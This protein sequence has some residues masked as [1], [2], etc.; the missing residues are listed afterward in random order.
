MAAQRDS[1]AFFDRFALDL[2][3]GELWQ[4][5]QCVD[6]P[7]QPTEVLTALVE[8]AGTLVERGDLRHR[9]WGDGFVDWEAGLHQAIR[10]LRKTLKDDARKPTFIETVPRRGYR[11]VCPVSRGDRRRVESRSTLLRRYGLVAAA[12]VVAGILPPPPDA[13]RPGITT[14]A[15]LAASA[16][17]S[18]AAGLPAAT[19]EAWRLHREG[20]HLLDRGSI[21][22]AITRLRRAAESAP[23]WGAPWGAIAEAEL[24]R[25][26]DQRI[27]SARAAIESALARDPD[28]ARAWRQLATLRLWEEWDWI[29]AR[30]ALAHA[31][32]VDSENADAWQLIASLETISGNED[33]ALAA[34]HRAVELDPVSTA[35]KAD[36]GWTFYYFGRAEKALNECRRGLELEPRSPS[37]R[38]C[39]LQALLL[40]GRRAEAVALIE[41]APAGGVYASHSG[42][43]LTDLLRSQLAAV[44][45]DPS[46]SSSAAAAVP[47]ILLG[48]SEGA[49]EALIAGAREGRGWEVPFAR[50]DPLLAPLRSDAR[51]SEIEDALR[52]SG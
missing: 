40:L 9:I 44:E 1:L 12:L 8:D 2:R 52:V 17:P 31:T 18:P 6:L 35:R 33:A 37:A 41:S 25:P 48:D 11:F 47:R 36:L 50:F 7:P 32:R 19:S 30:S 34:A 39:A 29:G 15:S 46:C 42:D 3:T 21:T 51:F 14:H 49:M 38:Q 5:D 43:P 28:E 4:G 13:G 10:R 24:M 23:L 45:S 22:Q 26:G 16:A 20:L 27:P